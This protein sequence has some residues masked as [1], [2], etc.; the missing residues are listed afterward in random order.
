MSEAVATPQAEASARVTRDD[1]GLRQ[2]AVVAVLVC[3]GYYLTAKLGFAFALHPG[4]VSTLWMPNSILLAALLLTP[5]RFWWIIIAAAFPAHLASELHNSVP[6]SMVLS[7]FLSNSVQGLL[8]AICIR[9]VIKSPLQLESFRHFT[10]LVLFGVFLAPFLSSFLDIGLVKLNGWSPAPFWELWRIRFLANVVAT[11][12]VVPVILTWAN[13][14]VEAL[15]RASLW[16]HCEAGL[17]AVC[18]FGVSAIVFSA[19]FSVTEGGPLLLYGPL[20][21][22]LWAAVRFGPRGTSTLLLVVMFLAIWGAVGGHGPFVAKSAAHNALSIQWFLIVVSIP[23][24]SLAVVFQERERAREAARENQEQLTMALDAAQ[25]GT[26]DWHINENT[27]RWSEQTKKIFGQSPADKLSAEVF[28][29][30]LHPDDRPAV[31]QAITL[32]IGEGAP[33]D[34]EF[35]VPQQ[36]GSVRWVRGKGKVLYDHEAGKA[37]RMVGLNADITERKQAEHALCESE[38]R[39]A[40]TEAFSL[41]M[42]THVGLDGRWLKVPPTLCEL[43]GYTEEE[44]LSVSFKDVTHPDDFQ[45]DWSQCQRLIRGEI[46]SFDL[47]KR[48]LRKDG[49]TLWIYLNCSVVEDSDGKPV[50][51]LTYIKDITDRKLAEEALRESEDRYRSMVESQTELI[52]RFLPDATLTYVND[53]YCRYFGK[54]REELIGTEFVDLLPA[55][56]R[57]WAKEEVASLV[58]N[59]RTEVSEHEVLLPDGRIGWQQW[60][61]HA[62]P[63]ADGK[64][65]ELQAIGR[66]ITERKRAEQALRESNA[67]NQAILRAL[68]DMMFLHTREGVYLDYYTRDPGSLL[69]PPSAFIGKNLREVL[70]AELAESILECVERLDGTDE[71]QVF[72][73]SLPIDDEDRY[74]EARLVGAEG[75]NVLSIVR[76]VTE[77]RRAADALRRGEEKLLESNREIR[78]LAARLITAQESERRRISLLL[79]D[80]VS[81]NIAALGVSISRLKRKPP[82]SS[83]QMGEELD[84]LGQQINNLTTQ[85]RHLSHQLH[86][87]VLEHV[88]LVAALQSQV[89][90]FSHEERIE[91]TFSAEVGERPLPLDISLGLYRVALEAMRNV[92]R[93]SGAKSAN[94]SLS[95]ADGFLTLE[96]SDSGRGFDVNKAK[97]GS[98]IGLVGAEERVKLLQGSLE[99]K[100]NRNLG[101]S[102]VARIPLVR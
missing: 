36:D 101:T 17:L 76:D 95:E 88:G 78:E 60:I 2:S 53:A 81:Q 28:F 40:R 68:P 18:L 3:A 66:D 102:L 13:G 32:A 50:H 92:S 14:G 62:I 23:M 38:A 51:F 83:E 63:G 56:I 19:Q 90:E 91:A 27:A 80:D 26:W 20:P 58:A 25:M 67:R 46:K 6:V 4:S 7:W 98:G 100:S 24:M 82:A 48:Y 9:K 34:A 45:A 16:R 43:L 22:L 87:D 72:E 84:R 99:I 69:L 47:E 79:H 39:L 97:R 77:T 74:F 64:I 70:P 11:L 52:C 54:S 30:M 37:S 86:P 42:V 93:H 10:A 73:Y 5:T 94:I 71:T 75:D 8:G 85:I 29:S 12:T 31:E 41:V 21:F 59:P 44:L 1:A 35:R 33:Y 61:N 57:A 96:V 49:K 55:P 15:R 65:L 89:S